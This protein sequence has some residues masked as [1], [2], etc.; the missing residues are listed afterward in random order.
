MFNRR[1]I[2]HLK[3][4]IE[5][6]KSDIEYLKR[7]YET[8]YKCNREF[9]LRMKYSVNNPAKYAPGYVNPYGFKVKKYLGVYSQ[10]INPKN[11]YKSL[12]HVYQ[13]ENELKMIAEVH[14][15]KVGND[16]IK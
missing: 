13:F 11:Y 10:G 6:L 9:E 1:K 3:I 14:V 2:K 5:C 4:E 15:D 8:A 16:I 7:C 12:T